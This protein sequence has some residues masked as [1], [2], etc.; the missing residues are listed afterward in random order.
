[1]EILSTV[2]L[3]VSG[4]A[5]FYVLCWLLMAAYFRQKHSYVERLIRSEPRWE[6]DQTEIQETEGGKE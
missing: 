5:V 3:V 1:M 6:Y 2:I 4:A